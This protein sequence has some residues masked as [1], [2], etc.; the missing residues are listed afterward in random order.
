LTFTKNI[1]NL[2]EIQEEKLENIIKT[3]KIEYIDKEIAKLFIDKNYE[4]LNKTQIFNKIYEGRDEIKKIKNEEKDYL[5]ENFYEF[6]KIK[7]LEIFST[8]TNEYTNIS[9]QE[10][11]YYLINENLI[12][13]EFKNLKFKNIIFLKN[14]EIYE[15]YIK[16]NINK[17]EELL[18]FFIKFFNNIMNDNNEIILNYIIKNYHE[19]EITIDKL[20]FLKIFDKNNKYYIFDLYNPNIELFKRLIAKEYLLNTTKWNDEIEFLNKIGLNSEITNESFLKCAKNIKSK[21]DSLLFFKHF[22]NIDIKN[23]DELYIFQ[24]ILNLKIFPIDFKLDVNVYPKFK[25]HNEIDFIKNSVKREYLDICFTQ[26]N[27][28]IEEYD[29]FHDRIENIFGKKF[30]II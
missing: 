8:F 5:C 10:I 15:K 9:S 18:D 22:N 4:F 13:N 6:S 24:N 12:T 3:I 29:H 30:N 19:N 2:D 21:D 17:K 23:F 11:E 28:L 25:I 26:R 20:K 14:K 16:N 27:F 7:E 1:I